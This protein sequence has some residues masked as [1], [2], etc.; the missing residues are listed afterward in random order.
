MRLVV[1]LALRQLWTRRLLSGI[2]TFAVTLGVLVLIVMAGIMLGFRRQF[3]D[4]LLKI[5]PQVTLFDRQVRRDPPILARW[6]AAL[7]LAGPTPTSVR[8]ELPS[9]RDARIPRPQEL[10]RAALAWPN[11]VAAAPSLWGSAVVALGGKELPVEVRGI[12]PIPQELVTPLTQYVVRG[13]LDRMYSSKE[14]IVLGVGVADK[15]GVQV[16]D[17]V[18]IAARGGSRSLLVVAV[19]DSAIPAVDN[20]RVYV[21]LQTAQSVLGRPDVV[22]RLELRVTHPDEAPE[23]ARKLEALSGYDAESWQETNAAFLGLF[24]VQNRIIGFVVGA[25]LLTGGFGILA[26]Q[27]M[28]VL[29]KTRDISILRSVGFRR[30]DILAVFLL[31]GAVVALFGGLVGDGLGYAI[32]RLLATV[33]IRIDG[34]FVKASSFI[35]ADTPPLYAAGLVFALVIGL[36]A[37]ALPALRASRVEPV[38]VLRGQIS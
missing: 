16:G 35:L 10:V 31:Q 21:A 26:I 5:S 25:V 36:L 12:E 28:I 30:K 18:R 4:N 13:G 38:D 3:L 27:I 19:F 17:H 7:G 15:L 8:H 14:S 37:S 11:V 34:G 33:K 20:G 32:C 9:D 2:A 6:Y 23:V 1:F 22:S 29:Q 24:E